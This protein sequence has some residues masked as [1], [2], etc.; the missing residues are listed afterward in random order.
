[1]PDPYGLIAPILSRMDAEAAHRLVLAALKAGCGGPF[2]PPEP[3]PPS[4]GTHLWGLSFS[5]PIGI[6]A[7]FDKNAE[8]VPALFRLGFG[9]VE[10]GGI[11]PR[12]QPGN[13]R[14]R[15]FRLEEDRAV[16]NRMGFNSEGAEAV[17]NRLARLGDQ[18]GRRWG[19]V[20]VNLAKNKE[21]A[22]A[23]ADYAAVARKLAPYADIIVIN[24]S[25][26]NTPGLRS[27]Q[28][29]APLQPIVRAVREASAGGASKPLLLKIAPD[30][31][32]DDIDAVTGL[33]VMEKLDGIVCTN[34]TTAR[35]PGL[36]SR[37][38]G[39]EGGLSG[40]PLRSR[41]TEVLRRVYAATHGKLPLIGVGGIASGADA[42]ARIRAGASVVQLYTAL[43]Y[44]GPRLLN[45]IKRDLASLLARDG[46]STVGA[47][48]G[49]DHGRAA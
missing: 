3:D 18:P 28:K 16:V 39:E 24:V 35:P 43:V 17:A 14:P 46:F 22:D 30:L 12:P 47:A 21:S 23:A 6:A 48:V 13:P 33:A 44:R 11:T 26:P 31:E 1:M 49:A 32:E 25:S 10:V 2:Y 9:F 34:T 36:L 38:R 29:V 41:A 40:A 27:L 7:G 42:Y 37:R 4:L 19:P 20:A 45:E 15:L 8:V 5:N